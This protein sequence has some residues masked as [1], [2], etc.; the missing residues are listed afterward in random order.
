RKIAPKPHTIERVDAF[1]PIERFLKATPDVEIVWLADGVDLG[2][3]KEF[4]DAL[5]RALDKR[6]ITVVE[7]GVKTAH[8]LAAADNAARALTVKVLR[9]ASGSGDLGVV[10]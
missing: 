2:R 1:A 8:A 6:P 7:G 3:A 4:V 5:A 9:A 10:R